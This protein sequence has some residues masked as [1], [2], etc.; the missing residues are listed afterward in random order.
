MK[1]RDAVL[2]LI[3]AIAVWAVVIVHS[4][5]NYSSF[6]SDLLYLFGRTGV[7]LFIMLT[8]ATMVSRDY[9]SFDNLKNHFIRLFKI[10]AASVFWLFVY[11]FNSDSILTNLRLSLGLYYSANHFWFLILLFVLYLTLPFASYLNKSST[12]AVFLQWLAIFFLT[13]A[14]THSFIN[15]GNG[16]FYA[17]VYLLWGY[18]CYSRKIQEKV[19]TPVIA[20]VFV[21][22]VVFSMVQVKSGIINSLYEGNGIFIWWYNSTVVM[23]PSLVLFPL[24]LR[25]KLKHYAVIEEFSCCSFGIY[26]V[27]MLVLISLNTYI[28]KLNI[29]NGTVGGL[30]LCVATLG[31][32][33]FIS[34]VVGKIPYLK[35]FILR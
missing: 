33:F 12:K 31:I 17:Y 28:E 1:Q 26:V 5:E 29:S 27:H 21:L 35:N 13:F 11:R 14:H 18:L 7:P 34:F 30:L 23:L 10:Y 6:K 15:L 19:P 8:G 24:L 22:T 16:Y 3:R 32:S 25:L 9:T 2:D 20:L 4:I